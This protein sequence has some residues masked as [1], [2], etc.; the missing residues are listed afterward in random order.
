MLPSFEPTTS[1]TMTMPVTMESMSETSPSSNVITTN[2]ETSVVES[3]TLAA[4]EMPTNA[5]LIGGVLG[6]VVALLLVVGVIA[7][8]VM[9]TRRLKQNQEVGENAMQTTRPPSGNYGHFNVA[10]YGNVQD[11][12]NVYEGVHDKLG[13]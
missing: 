4:A 2:D 13:N 3:T 12:Q 1:P 11:T 5:A 8:I 6:G 7:F 9:R 10:Q